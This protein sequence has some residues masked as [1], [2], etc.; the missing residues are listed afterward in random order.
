[1]CRQSFFCA[2]AASKVM[3]L[4]LTLAAEDSP[5]AETQD[6]KTQDPCPGQIL[7]VEQVSWRSANLALCGKSEEQSGGAEGLNKRTEMRIRLPV[8]VS[9]R[10]LWCEHGDNQLGV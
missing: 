2:C 5:R 7:A 8:L 1:M 3:T 6:S 9:G 10:V 4:R